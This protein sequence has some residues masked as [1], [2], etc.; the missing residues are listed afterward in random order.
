MFRIVNYRNKSGKIL[1]TI[2][3]DDQMSA[4]VSRLFGINNK[5]LVI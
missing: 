3:T 2:E 1:I 4:D 5:F